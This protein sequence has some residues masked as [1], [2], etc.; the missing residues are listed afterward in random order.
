LPDA[1]TLL[2][3]RGTADLN[4]PK[5]VAIVGTRTN[6]DY[7]KMI[8]E[9]LVQEL[10]AQ[11]ILIVSGLAYGIDATAHKAALK[12]GLPTVGVVGHGLDKIYPYA[13]T[14]LAKEMMQHGGLLT[15]FFSGTK[16]DKHNFPLRN[17]VVAGIAD[18]T[19]VVETLVNGGS[20]ITA[21]LADSY[22]RDVFAIPGRITDGKSAGCN[23]LI[24]HNKAIL[25][26]EARQ[27]LEV[28]G[29]T[30][31]EKKARK[32]Q[33][34]L[35]IELSEAEKKVVEVLQE[36]E[37]VH[38]DEL[39][40]RSGLSSSATAA[41]VLNLELQSAGA[42]FSSV[43]VLSNTPLARCQLLHVFV[44]VLS[45]HHSRLL[46]LR[47]RM[48]FRAA[49][50]KPTAMAAG[51]AKPIAQGQAITSTAMLRNK[52]GVNSFSTIQFT[53]SVSNAIAI[54]VGTKMALMRSAI[55]CI[56]GFSPCAFLPG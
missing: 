19:V 30:E 16:P 32:P 33:R 41:A 1:P 34:T 12:A 44:P 45:K 46:A 15:E 53:A 27:L 37:V 56:G 35:F 42:Y 28:M 9:K 39:N 22:N 49:R 36:K 51:V 20:M 8:T 10:A 23:H 31:G 52:A 21:K 48:P 3:Y 55:C 54:T 2:F 5:I 13:H 29:W 14:H 26:T 17:R 18:A 43:P 7:G 25:L 6:T 47:K 50:P 24:Q 40:L 11:N 38:L 4:T